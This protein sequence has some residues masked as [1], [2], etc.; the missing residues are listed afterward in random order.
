MRKP[1]Q[2]ATRKSQV[3]S[4]TPILREAPKSESHKT[5]VDALVTKVNQ[6]IADGKRKAE[7]KSKA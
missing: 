1:S 6:T 2:N 4:K 3:R 5:E 7:E